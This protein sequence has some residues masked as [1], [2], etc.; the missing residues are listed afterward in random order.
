M[1]RNKMAGEKAT[2]T[3]QPTAVTVRPALA[4]EPAKAK[5]QVPAKKME[6]GEVIL[7]P[8]MTEKAVRLTE[9]NKIVFVVSRSSGKLEI[10]NAVEGM[11]GVK[12]EKINTVISQHGKKKA[13]VLLAKE[14]PASELAS[15]LGML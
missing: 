13:Y 7:Y 8:Y 2:I 11:Y 5:P 10:K 4:K 12:V 14:F 3:E 6:L 1:R 15:K 9:K